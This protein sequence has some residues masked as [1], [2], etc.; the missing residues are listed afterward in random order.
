M[1]YTEYGSPEVLQL[2]EVPKPAPRDNEVLVRVH[3]TTVTVGGMSAQGSI[4]APY[5]KFVGDG[6]NVAGEVVVDSMD[7]G[8]EF[9]AWFFEGCLDTSTC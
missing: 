4:L 5:A 8:V 2:Q 7:T 9:H 3:A 1:V 6:G